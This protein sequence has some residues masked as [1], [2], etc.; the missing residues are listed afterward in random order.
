MNE[1]ASYEQAD[2]LLLMERLVSRDLRAFDE[3]YRRHSR[4]VFSL[5]LRILQDEQEAE[6]V[7]LDVF[8][9]LWERAE[10]FNPGRANP[11]TYLVTLTRSRAIDSLRKRRRQPRP[12]SSAAL[13]TLESGERPPDRVMKNEAAR[14]VQ[15]ALESLSDDER[16][17]LENVYYQGMT[18]TETAEA[19]QAPLGTVK[20]W[21]RRALKRMG[22]TVTHLYQDGSTQKPKTEKETRD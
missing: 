22:E 6:Q 20:T 7:L 5:C 11:R 16:Q 3:L 2:D 14:L 10:R 17:A 1:P 19:M 21:V 18:H 12:A 13:L 8:F 4:L 9:E 15:Q